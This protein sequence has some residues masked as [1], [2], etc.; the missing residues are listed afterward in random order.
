MAAVEVGGQ[1]RR[2]QAGQGVVELEAALQRVFL[3]GKGL[4]LDHGRGVVE[5]FFD[6]AAVAGQALQLDLAD[7][8]PTPLGQRKAKR[9]GHLRR[10]GGQVLVDELLLERHGGGGDQ[11]AALAR[12]FG[13]VLA[14]GLGGQADHV[15]AADQVDRDRLGEGRQRVRA[16]LADGLHGRGDAGAIDQ[17][18]QLAQARGGGH[19]GLAVGFLADVA[20]DEDTADVLRDLFAALDLQ[21]GDDDLAAVRGQHACR[22]FAEARGAAG[23]DEHLACDFHDEDLLG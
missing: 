8:T 17:A 10:Q 19:D 4:G 3:P 15:E 22:A 11:H 7:K 12:G 18:H 6:G 23:D 1:A 5:Q 2:Q 14:H 9:L 16:V 21:I 13:F 20:L